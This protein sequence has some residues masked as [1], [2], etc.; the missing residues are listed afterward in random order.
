MLRLLRIGQVSTHQ[1]G[2]L[3]LDGK[4]LAFT[5]E[6][7]WAGNERRK[8]CIPTGDYTLS[9]YNSKKFGS[10][11]LVEDVPGR[12]GILIHAGNT[13]SD[14]SGCILVGLQASLSA[15]QRSKDALAA[16]R[17]I[18]YFAAPQKISVQNA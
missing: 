12:T 14:T 9:P 18:P 10:V 11:W 4:P 5:L 13:V 1:A 2:V 3:L 7:P 8:S 16:L 17:A 15:L 6:L